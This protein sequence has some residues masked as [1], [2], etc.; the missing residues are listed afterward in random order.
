MEIELYASRSQV[1]IYYFF[2]LIDEYFFLFSPESIFFI[3]F[4]ES[5]RK[6][7][8]SMQERN[9][10]QLLPICTWTKEHTHNLGMCPDWKSNLQPFGYGTMS[11][12][13]EPHQPEPLVSIL[14]ALFDF[15]ITVKSS[16]VS[17]KT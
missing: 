16:I 11:Q 2:L 4:I 3:V 1:S 5:R 6:R 7:G 9:I 10:D 14:K 15:N 12:P 17:P 8:T 13:P